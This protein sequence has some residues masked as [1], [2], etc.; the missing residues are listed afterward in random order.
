ML[1]GQCSET[2]VIEEGCLIS[3]N[4][5]ISENSQLQLSITT[6]GVGSCSKRLYLCTTSY[7]E[8][9]N[10]PY[11]VLKTVKLTQTDTEKGQKQT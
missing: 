9:V 4:C 2:H 8:Q 6:E 11:S 3:D 1:L 10:W 5:F 7:S